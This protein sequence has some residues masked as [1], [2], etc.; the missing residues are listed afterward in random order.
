MNR[1]L[2][3]YLEYREGTLYWIKKP[4]RNIAVNTK[5][6]NLRPDGYLALRFKGKLYLNHRVIWFL[7]K[8]V[9]PEVIDH[10]D[11]DKTNNRIEN[12]RN[13]TQSQNRANQHKVVAQSG[14]KG[15]HWANGT[16]AARIKVNGVQT[17]IGYSKC[18][19]ECAKLYDNKAK[20]LFGEYAKLNFKE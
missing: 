2:A 8:G 14:Y 6:G 19:K 5:A 9:V 1:L 20:S 15:V 12:L 18:P 17:V 10:I 7:L 13:V 16:W 3:E 11:G 4:C